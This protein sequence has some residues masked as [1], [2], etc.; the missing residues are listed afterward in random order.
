[1]KLRKMLT[2]DKPVR[3]R[4]G[5]ACGS[6]G[7]IYCGSTVTLLK[8]REFARTELDRKTREQNRGLEERLR[9]K[10]EDIEAGKRQESKSD[11]AIE[12][13][14][15]P[16]TPVLDREVVDVYDSCDPQYTDTRIYIVTGCERLI[17]EDERPVDLTRIREDAARD[18][19][20]AVYAK[21]GKDLAN[22]YRQLLW[23]DSL[24]RMIDLSAKIRAKERWFQQDVYGILGENA[25]GVID[26]IRRMVE[27][28]YKEELEKRKG[29]KDGRKDSGDN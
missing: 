19:V 5:T 8:D 3:I 2:K 7:W 18:L 14:W 6:G 27:R 11:L 26:G 16:W 22:M 20:D 25:D 28:E 10:R 1:M 24:A 13:I 12:K 29:K 17:S 23:S 4:I 21:E 15:T 9:K